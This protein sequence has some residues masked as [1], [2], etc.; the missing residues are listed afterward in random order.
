MTASHGLS[1]TVT[2]RAKR[3]ESCPA[4]KAAVVRMS[5]ATC[6]RTMI[7]TERT[8]RNYATPREYVVRDSSIE[9]V[10]IFAKPQ[11]RS[12]STFLQR[13]YRDYSF[14]VYYFVTSIRVPLFTRTAC[15]AI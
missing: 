8:E 2:I 12:P 4:I 1:P 14:T 13:E 9:L 7:F 6:Q 11:P 3:S 15:L 5:P 10:R